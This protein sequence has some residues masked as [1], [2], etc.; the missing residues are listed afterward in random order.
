VEEIQGLSVI[1]SPYR[2]HDQVLGVLGVLGPTRMDY[3]RALS[4]VETTASLL[5]RSLTTQTP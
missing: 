5:S 3:G 2:R 4:L 1:A